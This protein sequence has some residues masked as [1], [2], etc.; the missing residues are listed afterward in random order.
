MNSTVLVPCILV[1]Y[2]IFKIQL[3]E[4][5]F[6]GKKASSRLLERKREGG[7][8]IQVLYLNIWSDPDHVFSEEEGEGKKTPQGIKF[9]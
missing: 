6:D 4:K 3:E 2:L 5:L 8:Q 9:L 1:F 7:N